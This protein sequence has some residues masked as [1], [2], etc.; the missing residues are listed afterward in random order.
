MT[1]KFRDYTV[2][3]IDEPGFS[4]GST[5]NLFK[6]DHVYYDEA[7][8]QPTSKHGIKVTKSG[9]SISSAI[10]CETAGATG[11]CNNLLVCCCDTVY[12]F[13]L[14]E[15]TLNWKK[16]LD[17]ATCFGIFSF[18]DDFI[19][20][21]ELAITRVA[22]NGEIKWSFSAKDIFVKQD[23]TESL[24]LT[25][26]RIEVIDWEGDKYVLDEQGQLTK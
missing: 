1:T 25:N 19:I 22:S 9:Q 20:H 17:L 13:R 14:P 21:G 4:P 5:D 6:Y 16:E 23:G 2:D 18:K 7:E 15:L 26:D 12:S 10:I 24:R 3:I 11:I 8:F